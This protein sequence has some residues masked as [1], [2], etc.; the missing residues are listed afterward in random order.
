MVSL[1]D[2]LRTEL[3][4]QINYDKKILIDRRELLGAGFRYKLL[5]FENS[6]FAIGT[7]Y[8]FEHEIYDLNKNA[9]HN[10]EE[11]VS[12]WS[13]YISLYFDLNSTAKFGGVIYY[14]PLFSDFSDN[15]ILSENSLTISITKL[16]SI[17]L[18]FRIRHD[19]GPPDGIKDTD[20]QTRVGL[21]MR[22]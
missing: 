5:D 18:N 3:F 13:N 1:T 4:T 7:A 10:K 22:F 17:S 16:F 12:R 20:T 2:N 6:D 19:S 11:S 15:R 8:M 14:Q 9:V 21:A